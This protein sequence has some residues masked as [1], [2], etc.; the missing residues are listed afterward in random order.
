MTLFLS[1]LI[2]FALIL[3]FGCDDH[4]IPVCLFVLFP[5]T[6]FGLS[7]WRLV[8]AVCLFVWFVCLSIWFVRRLLFLFVYLFCSAI[9][10]LSVCLFGDL[11]FS[12]CLFVLFDDYCFSVCLPIFFQDFFFCFSICSVWRLVLEDDDEI[13]T[14]R[15][16]INVFK[17]E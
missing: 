9:S 2:L 4:I 10:F 13:Q 12:V 6:S 11:F 16:K 7:V 3:L 15:T 5:I 17:R 1:L 14:F 8:F